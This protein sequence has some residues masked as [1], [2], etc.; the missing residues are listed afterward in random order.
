MAQ[1]IEQ[2]I[3]VLRL[4]VLVERTVEGM[5]YLHGQLQRL[6]AGGPVGHRGSGHQDGP[7]EEACGDRTHNKPPQYV[8]IELCQL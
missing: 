8:L 4:H 6:I 3:I 2:D 5:G 1:T 7:V